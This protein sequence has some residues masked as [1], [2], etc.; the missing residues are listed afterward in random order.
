MA[1]SHDS[2]ASRLPFEALV[3]DG[4]GV[5]TIAEQGLFAV[6][7]TGHGR[8]RLTDL[9]SQMPTRHRRRSGLRQGA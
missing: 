2:V 3:K 7:M 9:S 4:C 6:V 8:D 5:R 1:Q